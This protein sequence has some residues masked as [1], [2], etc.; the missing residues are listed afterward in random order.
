M[1]YRDFPVYSQ[2]AQSGFIPE[3]QH[4]TVRV[5]PR[6]QPVPRLPLIAKHSKRFRLT[7][8]AEH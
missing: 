1:Q 5:L 7:A 8:I 6:H 4:P 3:K 2:T